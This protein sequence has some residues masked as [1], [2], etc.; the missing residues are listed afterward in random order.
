MRQYLNDYVVFVQMS[1]RNVLFYTMH[2]FD[3]LFIFFQ[4]KNDAKF[5]FFFMNKLFVTNRFV[6]TNFFVT[7]IFRKFFVCFKV[8][9]ANC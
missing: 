1:A 9:F 3:K 8:D 6:V 4:S 5:K 2:Y 7:L